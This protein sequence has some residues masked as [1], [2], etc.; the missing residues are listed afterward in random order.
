[1]ICQAFQKFQI[2][3]V[4][5]YFEQEDTNISRRSF[6]WIND[7]KSW[8]DMCRQFIYNTK[9]DE[10]LLYIISKII[11]AVTGFRF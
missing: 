6:E 7:S 1:M 3:S 2:C 10:A 11:L 9:K 5:E 8:N 4:Q